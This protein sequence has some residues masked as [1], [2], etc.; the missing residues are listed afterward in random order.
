MLIIGE[1]INGTRKEVGAAIRERDRSVIECLAREQVEAGAGYLDV[2]AG[3]GSDTEADDLVWLVETAQEVVDVPLCLDSPSGS[4]LT[5]AIE[6]T[7]QT[8]MVNSISGEPDRTEHVLPL[9]ARHQCPVILVALDDT[10][11]PE[12]VDDRL[13]IVDRLVEAT[14]EAGVTDDKLYIDPLVMAIST[15]GEAGVIAFETMRQVRARYPDAHLT[16]GLS[17][18]SYGAP[19][20]KL[21]NQ[22]FLALAIDAGMD[23]AIMDPTAPGMYPALLAA[24]AVLGRDR[25]CSRYN[26]AHRAGRLE[27]I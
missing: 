20:R 10:G 11:I 22:A 7:Q 21:L 8:P 15:N 25:F 5:I 18:I 4:T 19:A 14:R 13:V 27:P 6:A 2:N 1:K 23:S 3:S 26:R 16:G 12:T 24:E 17:N 9:V